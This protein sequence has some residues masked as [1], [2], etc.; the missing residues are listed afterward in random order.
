MPFADLGLG[1]IGVLPEQPGRLHDHA[2]RA[3][4]ALEAVL[5]PERLLERVERG[6]IGHAFDGLDLV[7]IRLDREDGARLG[8]LAV[9]VDRAGAAVA[10]VAADVR[11]GQ[12]ERVAQEVDE[13]ETGFD[14]RL[15]GRPVDGDADVLG[16]HRWSVSLRVG[17]CAL[18][19]RAGGPE[20]HLRG[21]RPLVFDGT[22]DIAAGICS[23]RR[24]P[25]RPGGTG[26]SDGALPIRI[27]SASVAA[28]GD[29]GDPGHADAGAL[30]RPV[31]IQPDEDGDPD[32]GEVADLALELLVRAAGDLGRRDSRIWVRTSVGSIAVVKVSRKNSRAWIVRSPAWLVQ[33]IVALVARRNAGQSDAGSAWAIEPPIVPQLRTCGSPMVLVMST[34]PG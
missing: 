18:D 16:A 6:A 3:E 32:R 27:A 7:A 29:R 28:N 23:A 4:A 8:A 5:V 30:D 12:A 9:E 31:R 17:E 1:R 13:Q 2:R 21:H 10:R 24:R 25:H 15:L 20:G 14:V 33:T 22:P 34:M 11:A 19:G 26:A